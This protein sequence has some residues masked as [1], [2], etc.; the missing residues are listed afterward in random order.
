MSKRDS[1]RFES[2][3]ALNVEILWV[4]TLFIVALILVVISRFR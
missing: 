3:A 2:R 1:N 4:A